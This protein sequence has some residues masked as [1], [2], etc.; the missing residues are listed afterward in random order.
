MASFDSVVL[1][2]LGCTW[3]VEPTLI[4]GPGLLV[5]LGAEVYCVKQPLRVELNQG[6]ATQLHFGS[7][8]LWI[9]WQLCGNCGK[10]WME[11]RIFFWQLS[12]QN[13]SL[14]SE[15]GMGNW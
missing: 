4:P 5:P 11:N 7:P 9:V 3:L 15:M 8:A 2:G 1:V 13:R 14:R 6:R 12:R 10:I